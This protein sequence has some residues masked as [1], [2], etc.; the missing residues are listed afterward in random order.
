MQHH[1]ALTQ[2][3]THVVWIG[4][5]PCAG[6]TSIADALA[7]KYHGVA[8]H[9]DRMEMEHIARSSTVTNP[10]LMAF[11]A[12][13]MDH[14][15]LLR[16][17]EEMARNAIASWQ[18]RFPLVLED[19]RALPAEAL[20]FAEGPG[21]FPECVAPLLTDPRQ[22]I[23]LVSTGPFCMA[24]REQR[25]GVHL[26]TRDPALCLRN[27]VERDMLMAQYVKQQASG[28]HFI[29]HEVDGSR[30]LAQMTALVE[31]HFEPHL[32]IRLD[33]VELE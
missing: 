5:S 3:L 16:S 26:E 23:W 29:C 15:W 10:D 17:P 28:C 8:Y 20:I 32:H 13:D 14:R 25:R 22:A 2:H 24:A 27:I 21:L 9:F 1:A 11:L 7:A 4:G 12:M 19:L 30:S 31:Q 33:D 6:K 18:G